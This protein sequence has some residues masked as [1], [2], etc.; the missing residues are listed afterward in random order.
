MGL[1]RE[2][3]LTLSGSLEELRAELTEGGLPLAQ[4]KGRPEFLESSSSEPWVRMLAVTR[5]MGVVGEALHDLAAQPRIR[6]VLRIEDQPHAAALAALPWEGLCLGRVEDNVLV[7]CNAPLASREWQLVRLHD[8]RPGK[9]GRP[10]QRVLAVV[11]DVEPGAA[12]SDYDVISATLDVLAETFKDNLDVAVTA[13][14]HGQFAHGQGWKAERLAG[15]GDLESRLNEDGGYDL[16]LMVLHGVDEREGESGIAEANALAFGWGE[17]EAGRVPVY[18]LEDGDK[19]RTLREMFAGTSTRAILLF[20]CDAQERLASNFTR[21]IDHVVGFRKPLEVPAVKPLIDG[22]FQERDRPLG[23]MLVTARARLGDQAAYLAH[24]AGT[25]TDVAFPTR[26]QALER[27]MAERDGRA[28]RTFAGITMDRARPADLVDMTIELPIDPDAELPTDDEQ[29][30]HE[31][32]PGL[33]LLRHGRAQVLLPSLLVGEAKQSLVLRGVPGSGKSTCLR[34]AGLQLGE[35]DRD[36]LAL[37]VPISAWLRARELSLDGL[38]GHLEQTLK[39]GDYLRPEPSPQELKAVLQGVARAGRLVLL[40]DGLDEAGDQREFAAKGGLR[41]LID[42]LEGVT[43]VVSTRIEG[44]ER[45][46]GIER[47]AL[48]LPL[49]PEG[50]VELLAG[51]YHQARQAELLPE[52]SDP[53]T[54]AGE[55]VAGLASVGSSLRELAEV[56]LTLALI[57]RLRVAKGSLP[58]GNRHELLE[59]FMMHLLLDEHHPSDQRKPIREDEDGVRSVVDVLKRTA[60]YLA[61]TGL[62][63]MPRGD[64]VQLWTSWDVDG[65]GALLAGL[66]RRGVLAPLSPLDEQGDWQFLHRSLL[67]SLIARALLE[68]APRT[69]GA[70]GRDLGPLTKRLRLILA[71]DTSSHGTSDPLEPWRE[72]LALVT[73]YLGQQAEQ[74]IGVLLKGRATRRVALEAVALADGLPLEL[75]KGMLDGACKNDGER[76]LFWQRLVS[77]SRNDGVTLDLAQWRVQGDRELS[78]QEMHAIDEGLAVVAGRG[79]GERVEVLLHTLYGAPRFARLS[80]DDARQLFGPALWVEVKR[81]R[82]LEDGKRTLSFT[83]GEGE[84]AVERELRTDYWMAR[85]QV[86]IEQF[87]ACGRVPEWDPFDYGQLPAHRVSWFRAFTFC[88]WLTMELARVCGEPVEVRLP[89]E[90]EW[91]YACRGGHVKQVAGDFNLEHEPLGELGWHRENSKELHPVGELKSNHLGLYDMH[92]NV[93]EWVQDWYGPLHPGID[94]GG[95]LGGRGRVQRGGGVWDVAAGCRSAARS[96]NRPAGNRNVRGFRLCLPSPPQFG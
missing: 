21:W 85:T 1:Y 28:L 94:R 96:W 13:T 52:G 14:Q 62:Q 68:L 15:P 74:W 77:K 26:A 41:D 27:V 90:S 24:W 93:D 32:R 6:L 71:K 4:W 23:E 50:Q 70:R 63:G 12:Q 66:R 19:R 48:L 34:R 60:F 16:V 45:V 92:G 38:V 88:R 37:Y 30:A 72:P 65:P 67:E 20:A 75:A 91:E 84:K 57:G 86:T 3:E 51:L 61:E 87:E 10:L 39:P 73:G 18:R 35:Q 53:A 56:P 25:C 47:E 7:E 59:Q 76:D 9:T 64:F 69:P 49:T 44:Y 29:A 82:L 36:V 80:R 22:L 8:D 79:E 2:I 83:M 78:D 54:M 58:T 31:A 81:E 46:S 17:G 11:G 42:A 5:A 89:T 95:A 40:F 33:E 43:C 55:D